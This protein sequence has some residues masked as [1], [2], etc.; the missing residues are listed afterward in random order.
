MTVFSTQRAVRPLRRFALFAAILFSTGQ[1]GAEEPWGTDSELAVGERKTI[2][3]YVAPRS[4]VAQALI[5]FHQVV[6]SPA[7][8]PRSHFYPSSSSYALDAI[9]KHGFVTGYLLTCDRLQ[10]ENSEPWLYPLICIGDATL[11]YDPVP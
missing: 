3:P 11:K 4:G 9:N 7:D 6:L 10:R 2:R 5:R 8:G 1:L